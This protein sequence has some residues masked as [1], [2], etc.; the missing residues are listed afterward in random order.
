MNS[1]KTSLSFDNDKDTN[2]VEETERDHEYL[3]DYTLKSFCK[4]MW[5]KSMDTIFSISNQSSSKPISSSVSSKSVSAITILSEKN[6][7]QNA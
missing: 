6:K 4:K 7:I 1:I 5:G 3:H 2:G